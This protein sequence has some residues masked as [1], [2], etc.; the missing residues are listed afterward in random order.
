VEN[1]ALGRDAGSTLIREALNFCDQFGFAE[2]ELWKFRGSDAARR[3]YEARGFEL[4][5]ERSGVRWSRSIVEQRFVRQSRG[6]VSIE[7]FP[8]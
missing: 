1:A 5:E 2:A 6:F 7:I 3:L 4:F 8:R